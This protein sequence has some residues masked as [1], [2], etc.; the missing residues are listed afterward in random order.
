MEAHNARRE[1]FA[2]LSHA[3]YAMLTHDSPQTPE[4]AFVT[5]IIMQAYRDLL[6]SVKADGSSAFT[7]Q[8]DQD[9]AISFLTDQTGSFARHRNAL[10]SLIGWNG[11]VLASRIRKMMEGAD[12]PP[13]VPDPSPVTIARHE[14]AVD[15]IRARWQHLKHPKGKRSAPCNSVEQHPHQ[16]RLY[17]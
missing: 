10:C 16:D 11:D 2:R 1:R 3:V 4:A 12:F 6:I 9:Q 7:T 13:P 17:A 15:H 14:K 8:S 5:A